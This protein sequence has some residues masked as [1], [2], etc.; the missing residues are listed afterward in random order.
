MRTYIGVDYHRGFSY[1]TA[2]DERGKVRACGRVANDRKAVTRACQPGWVR[3]HCVG[4]D[5]K[6]DSDV[7]GAA[8]GRSSI[9]DLAGLDRPGRRR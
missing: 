9:S 1:M 8:N 6:L 5:P 7:C 3:S 4:G 2:M